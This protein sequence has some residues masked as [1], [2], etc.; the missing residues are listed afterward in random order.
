MYDEAINDTYSQ[1]YFFVNDGTGKLKNT[2][3]WKVTDPYAEA[4]PLALDE[5]PSV[6]NGTLAWGDIDGDKFPDLLML[7]E[8]EPAKNE[9]KDKTRSPHTY[10]F[11]NTGDKKSY[12]TDVTSLLPNYHNLAYGDAAWADFNNDG[13]QDLIMTGADGTNYYTQLYQNKGGHRF[14]GGI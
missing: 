2:Y 7:G 12:M 8:V 5:I 11:K 9:N 4:F 3:D 13:W 14:F 10:L 1:R 6:E